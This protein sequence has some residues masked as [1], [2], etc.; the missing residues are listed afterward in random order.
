MKTKKSNGKIK[1]R[2]SRPVITEG[3]RNISEVICEFHDVVLQF[4]IL[5]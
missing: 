3:A 1:L 2:L 5:I 4:V